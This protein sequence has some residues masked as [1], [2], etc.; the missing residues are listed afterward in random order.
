MVLDLSKFTIVGKD[1]GKYLLAESKI[2]VVDTLQPCGYLPLHGCFQSI[3]FLLV[4]TVTLNQCLWYLFTSHRPPVFPDT[5]WSTSALWY[6]G[7][8]L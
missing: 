7:G 4:V 5:S 1:V 2:L 8:L 3:F 6:S